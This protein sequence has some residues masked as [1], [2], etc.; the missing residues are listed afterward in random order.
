MVI[1]TY[2]FLTAQRTQSLSLLGDIPSLFY[3]PIS[4][5]V[6]GYPSAVAKKKKKKSLDWLTAPPPYKKENVKCTSTPRFSI[7]VNGN[8]VSE[9]RGRVSLLSFD[10]SKPHMTKDWE[11]GL[12]KHMGK[13]K[14]EVCSTQF[15]A[16]GFRS[17]L[18]QAVV[19]VLPTLFQV[20]KVT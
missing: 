19:P 14:G 20:R 4:I 10:S 1:F 13:D 2:N 7:S 15:R 17:E 6:L 9:K 5:L 18:I 3:Q 8:L 16:L 12:S 11:K